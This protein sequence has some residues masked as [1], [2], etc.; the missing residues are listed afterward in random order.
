MLLEVVWIVLTAYTFYKALS[1]PPFTPT[2]IEMFWI[3]SF[4]ILFVTT[5]VILV[6]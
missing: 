1:Q 4:T 6:L 2:H 5:P 3:M